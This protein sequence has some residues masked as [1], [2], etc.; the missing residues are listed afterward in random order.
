MAFKHRVFVSLNMID[1]RML[2]GIV[3]R[4]ILVIYY[5]FF[6][7]FIITKRIGARNINN[8]ETIK[9]CRKEL[10]LFGI[11]NCG[12]FIL[13]LQAD[14]SFFFSRAERNDER[15]EKKKEKNGR[16]DG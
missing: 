12:R 2:H 11:N 3:C 9:F 1:W 5:F 7:S 8:D 4:F 16:L 15:E 10:K 14:G 13:F 6:Y